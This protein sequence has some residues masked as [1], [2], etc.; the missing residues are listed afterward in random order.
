MKEYIERGIRIPFNPQLKTTDGETMLI[1]AAKIYTNKYRYDEM[2]M[3]PLKID[4][5]KSIKHLLHLGIDVNAKDN[6]NKTALMY[7]SDNDNT[8]IIKLLL[9]KGATIDDN[10]NYTNDH[11]QLVI[12]KNRI[13]H[14]E[15]ELL[16]L[17]NHIKYMPG[18]EGY[19]EA[20]K[21]F[22]SFN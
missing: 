13:K 6:Y 15:T 1:Y 9:E 8:T 7:A 2:F 20:Q 11:I 3:R 18:G 21:E 16:E 5:S 12:A 4:Q 14:L 10:Y 17:K 22:S 19:H